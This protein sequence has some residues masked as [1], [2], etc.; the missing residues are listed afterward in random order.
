MNEPEYIAAR[1][2]GP[3]IHLGAP[4]FR[5]LDGFVGQFPCDF[6]TSVATS[7]ISHHDLAHWRDGASMM[8]K[9]SQ[10]LFLVQDRHDEGNAHCFL[11][12]PSCGTRQ[13]NRNENENPF[14]C[15][16]PA[17][18]AITLFCNRRSGRN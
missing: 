6:E 13:S 15:A 1:Q 16:P 8:K 10:D 14:L 5:G 12:L 17:R 11:A 18:F 4:T 7:T 2:S 3:C 9:L